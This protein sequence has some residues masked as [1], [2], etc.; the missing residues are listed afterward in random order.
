MMKLLLIIMTTFL[1]QVSASSFGQKISIAETNITLENTLKKIRQQTGFD[2]I[3]DSDVFQSSGKLKVRLQNAS[4]EDALKAIFKN[5]DVEYSIEGKSVVITMKKRSFLDLIADKI[6]A[7]GIS[8]RIYDD[9]G[10][11]LAGATVTLKGSSKASVT[12]MG[13]DWV[14]SDVKAGDVLI[15]T[16]VGF[17]S[18]EVRLTEQ[19]IKSG[20][21]LVVRMQMLNA[22]LEEVSIVNTGYQQLKREKVTGAIVTLDSKEIEK[23][24]TINLFDNLEGTI[25]GLIRSKERNSTTT[26][27]RGTSTISANRT[28]LVV[29]DGFP[30]EGSVDNLNPYD[31]ESINVLKDAAA[32]AIYGAR[33]ANGVIVVTTKGA[34]EKNKTSVEFSANVNYFQKPDY[35]LMNLLTPSQQVDYESSYYDWYFKGAGGQ[36]P[37]PILSFEN[38]RNRGTVYTPIQYAYYQFTKN[39]ATYTQ[40]QLDDQ[41]NAYR[42]N[43][44]IN[45]FKA[46]ALE[47]RTVQQ[48]NFAVRTNNGRSQNSLVVNYQADNS[49]IINAYNRQINIFY[50]GNYNVTKWLDLDYGINGVLGYA[51]NHNNSSAT[52]PTLVSSYQTLFN[53][54]GSRAYYDPLFVS[55]NSYFN[56]N[57]VEKDPNLRSLRFNNLDELERDFAKTNTFNTRYYVGL[58]AKILPGL[59]L[60]P[61]F[62]YEDNKRDVNGYSEPESYTMRLLTNQFT[63]RTGT[64]PNYTYTNLVP[65][66]GRIVTNAQRSPSY[67]A[68]AQADYNRDFGKNGISAIAGLEFR[69][70]LTSGRT[71]TQYGYNDQLQ[72][73]NNL[74]DYRTINSAAGVIPYWSTLT[75]PGILP[76]SISQEIKHRFASAYANLTYTYDRKYNIFGS[77]RKDYADIFGSDP[78]YRGRPLWSVGGA[79]VASNEEF[80]RQY[81]FID[82]LKLRGSY[83]LTGNVDLNATSLLVATAGI[84]PDTQETNASIAT[85]PNAQLRWE[86][87]ASVDLGLDFNLFKNRLRGSFD[88]Y[89]KSSSD[90]LSAKKLDPSEGWSTLNINNASI[91]NKGVELS[92]AYDWLKPNRSDK[93]SITTNIILTHNKGE[94]TKADQIGSNLTVAQ[95]GGYVQ[96]YSPNSLFSIR[97]A[98]LN[99][100]GVQQWTSANGTVSSTNLL[101]NDFN[102]FVYSGVTTPTRTVGFNNDFS[103]RGFTLSVYMVYNGGHVFRKQFYRD[104]FLQAPSTF[105]APGYIANSWTPTNTNTNVP[106]AGRYFVFNAVASQISPVSDELIRPAD[107]IK[108][109][110]LVFGY[111][112][113]QNIARKIGAKSVR[114]RFQVNN[115]RALW[116]KQKDLDI[117]LESGS[118]YT[119]GFYNLPTPVSYVFGVTTNF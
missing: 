88:L 29:V 42:Q 75:S 87:T 113:S 55:Y 28:I 118:N 54:D 10:A 27:I 14:L 9:K 89:R 46:N 71:G 17:Q 119:T 76:G 114:L 56:A 81:K 4:L 22:N 51:R 13:G 115:M 40:T 5:S 41:L 26:T 98:G 59:T 91:V 101:T 21:K 106:G 95:A 110:T 111:D 16:F 84:N 70:T 33:A 1:V 3:V 96:G 7:T 86:Q 24:N 64:A 25:P 2:F 32:A 107:F 38:S 11:P 73:V 80:L 103:Y 65:L 100:Q 58:N 72:T 47:N 20:E 23:R 94:V 93:L 60:S 85:P 31:I 66:G 12:G 62:Q 8:G 61:R 63:T 6:M 109:R 50:K 45:E 104:G 99:A 44:F 37:N 77:I 92:L 105:P 74:I 108:I 49:G 39:P 82:F 34:K 83:G 18:K 43:N 53:A 57:V 116:M 19:M 68:R 52:D 90:V 78:E 48:Y 112:L 79:W 30:I 102:N 117:D 69:Q 97:S 67:T 15:F 36:L 35:S